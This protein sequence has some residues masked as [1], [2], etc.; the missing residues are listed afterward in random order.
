MNSSLIAEELFEV[1]SNQTKL[2]ELQLGDEPSKPLGKG[3]L[4]FTD[5]NFDSLIEMR[6]MYQT[7][8][9]EAANGVRT[10]LGSHVEHIPAETMRK[11][12]NSALP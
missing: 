9:A 8:Q 6:F 3:S 11:N 1:Q 7:R 10:K 5:L 4:T 2:R 12:N